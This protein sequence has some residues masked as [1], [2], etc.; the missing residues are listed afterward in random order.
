MRYEYYK[1]CVEAGMPEEKIKELERFFDA[2]KKKLNNKKKRKEQL[3]IL[4]LSI[5]A[6]TGVYAE[7]ETISFETEM[8]YKEEI[9]IIHDIINSFGPSDREFLYDYFYKAEENISELARMHN[10]TR[11]VAEIR[12]KWLIKEMR[13]KYFKQNP[14][15]E[16]EIFKR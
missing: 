15:G 3:S 12:I 7:D 16:T 4:A 11:R 2:E 13:E 1:A 10:V 6:E 8:L 5:D 14:I 9:R